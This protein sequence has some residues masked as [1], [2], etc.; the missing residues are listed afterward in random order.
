MKQ[1][2]V[3][4]A[5]AT[6]AQAIVFDAGGRVAEGISACANGD[7]IANYEGAGLFHFDCRLGGYGARFALD[8]EERGRGKSAALRLYERNIERV[9]DY[10]GFATGNAWQQPLQRAPLAWT[11]KTEMAL[12]EGAE[13]PTFW[14]RISGKKK[15]KSEEEKYV[16]YEIVLKEGRVPSTKIDGWEPSLEDTLTWLPPSPQLLCESTLLLLRFTLNG[17]ISTRNVRWDNIRNAWGVML[18]IQEKHGSPG[19]AFCPLASLVSSLLFPPSETGGDQIG[20]GLLARGLHMMGETLRLGNPTTEEEKSTAIREVIADRD[21]NFWLPADEEQEKV[22]QE[23]V[24]DFSSALDGYEDHSDAN[25]Q[26]QRHLR[27]ECWDFEARPILEHA[28]VYSACKSGDTKSLSLAR[29]ICSQGVTL[30]PNSPEEWWRYSIVLGLLGDEVGSEDALSNS[31][32]VGGG[33]GA[34]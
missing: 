24:E 31:I 1:N 16:Y 2:K 14:E 7:G 12:E 23:I 28:V 5:V 13:A 27:F 11:E 18:K 10:S 15:A 8:R 25:C 29:A 26:V 20:N 6:W 4:G 19:V 17:T 30:R 33:Q 9:L 32:N 34:R 22:W 21:P 3:T